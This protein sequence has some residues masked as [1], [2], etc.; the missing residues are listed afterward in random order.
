MMPLGYLFLRTE[1][2]R[3][4]SMISFLMLL[5]SAT[6][7]L[8]D[9]YQIIPGNW[10]GTRTASYDFK[11]LVVDVTT[12]PIYLCT[13]SMNVNTGAVSLGCQKT[14][15]HWGVTIPPGPAALSPLGPG[16]TLPGE[17]G[18]AGIWKVSSV[19]VTFCTTIVAGLQPDLYC[20]TTSLP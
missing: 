10:T 14:T 6:M 5:F 12:G 3:M 20:A 16:T 17:I 8:A 9:D 1:E 4:K 15:V 18:F 2:E 7:A 19:T 11:A 13:G